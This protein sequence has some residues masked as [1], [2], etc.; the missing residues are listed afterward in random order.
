MLKKLI[1]RIYKHRNPA[2]IVYRTS[3]AKDRLEFDQPGELLV[4]ND[5]EVIAFARK[6][7][8]PIENSK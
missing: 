6:Y 1:S 4:T 7:R 5:P 2:V 3:L 8:H